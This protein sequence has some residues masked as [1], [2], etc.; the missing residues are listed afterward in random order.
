MPKMLY[1]VPMSPIRLL[2]RSVAAAIAS[3]PVSAFALENR[4]IV[5]TTG[6]RISFANAAENVVSF[7]AYSIGGVVTV[8]FLVGAT[9]L[10]ASAGKPERV[11]TGK[12]LMKGSLIGMAIVL[13]SYMILRTVLYFVY[14]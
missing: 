3:L 9:F 1:T 11:E 10:I 12:K 2:I 8:L 4:S 14:A 7:A 6:I 13:S 5:M